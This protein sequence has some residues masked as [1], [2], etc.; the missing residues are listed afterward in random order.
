MFRAVKCVPKRLW[1]CLSVPENGLAP[2]RL[3]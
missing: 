2:V 3:N 1:V